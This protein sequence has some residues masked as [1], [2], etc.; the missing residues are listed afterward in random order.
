MEEDQRFSLSHYGAKNHARGSGSSDERMASH[1]KECPAT[2]DDEPYDPNS[3]RSLFIDSV[4]ARLR[5]KR[6]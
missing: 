2:L 6:T 1:R 5:G 3:D 4:L